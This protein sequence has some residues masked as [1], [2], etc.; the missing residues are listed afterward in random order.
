MT[1][2]LSEAS[3]NL[4]EI[5]TNI[6]DAVKAVEP[7][8][9]KL[10]S[11]IDERN[12]LRYQLEDT[13]RKFENLSNQLSDFQKK[14]NDNSI[15]FETQLQTSENKIVSLQREVDLLTMDRQKLSEQLKARDE[16][17]RTL[18]SQNEELI[19]SIRGRPG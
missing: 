4:R 19:Q 11:L 9:N 14:L 5:Q 10:S 7:L 17:I 15:G 16:R 6:Q 12:Q 8:F 2:S 1:N 18:E 13:Q 3:R